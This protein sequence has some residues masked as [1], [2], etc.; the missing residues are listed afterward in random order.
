M[1]E[2]SRTYTVPIACI[3]KCDVWSDPVLSDTLKTGCPIEM[4]YK[5]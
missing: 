5:L 1:G 2:R 4:E 3:T